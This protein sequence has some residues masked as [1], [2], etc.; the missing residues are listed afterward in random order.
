MQRF[1][2]AYRRTEPLR[3]IGNLDMHKVWERFLRRAGIPVAY[4]Q[5]FHPQPKVQQA[6]PIPLGF[7]SD[8]D[9]VDVWTESQDCAAEEISQKLIATSQPG[10]E[11]IRV[12]PVDLN[13]AALPAQVISAEF[14]VVLLD[15]CEISQLEIAINWI[16]AQ[17]SILREKR[18]KT[19]DLRPLIEALE[20]EL[21]AGQEGVVIKMRLAAREA[22][23]G[24][25]EE[26]LA[27]LALDP[28]AA[29]YIRSKLL[30]AN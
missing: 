19:Y 25:P 24:R 13:E 30:F 14:R 23:T 4:S 28:Y 26:V 12:Y 29:R 6:A 18:G 2:I 1:R 11:V 9:L 8:H 15:P 21:P 27:Q 7:L 10:I 20:V 5:G 17:T 16:M 3:Y 22:A